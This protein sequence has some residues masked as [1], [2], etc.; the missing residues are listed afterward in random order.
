MTYD[1]ML[2]AK[3]LLVGEDQILCSPLLLCRVVARCDR[4]V[5][6]SRLVQE[7]RSFSIINVHFVVNT[8]G[9]A[10]VS[11]ISVC[12]DLVGT[13]RVDSW[14]SSES[15]AGCE[16]WLCLESVAARRHSLDNAYE[17]EAL[18]L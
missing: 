3:D 10:P 4:F 6:R 11:A 18:K 12:M 16:C 8:G 9:R 14:L 15:L 2:G 1:L 17:S 7:R 13:F 5:L